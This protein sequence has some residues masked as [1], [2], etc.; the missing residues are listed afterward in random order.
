MSSRP[1]KSVG[2]VKG[3]S[4]ERFGLC[5]EIACTESKIPGRTLCSGS[6][7]V[8]GLFDGAGTLGPNKYQPV[9]IWSDS[10]P[11]DRRLR[12]YDNCDKYLK[13]HESGKNKPV[14]GMRILNKCNSKDSLIC[15]Y[16]LTDVALKIMYR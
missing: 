13:L 16:K 4:L 1:L 8:Y 15:K 9:S 12:F 7:F 11:S 5:G 2:R 14:S 3:T 6:A 10:L